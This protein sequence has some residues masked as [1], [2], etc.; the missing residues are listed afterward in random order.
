[1]TVLSRKFFQRLVVHCYESNLLISA[2]LFLMLIFLRVGLHFALYG[3][4]Q[5]RDF[6]IFYVLF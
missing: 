3:S 6:S 2:F 4:E 1:M 5:R